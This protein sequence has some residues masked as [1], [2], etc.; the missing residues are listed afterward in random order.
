MTLLVG[1]LETELPVSVFPK[2]SCKRT[3]A[4]L[5]SVG[6]VAFLRRPALVF[7]DAFTSDWQARSR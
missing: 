4:A 3:T 6:Y 7:G 1:P 5:A 2:V